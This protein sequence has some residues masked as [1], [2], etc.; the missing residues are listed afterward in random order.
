M[1]GREE[2][3]R[4]VAMGIARVLDVLETLGQANTSTVILMGS[5]ARELTHDRSDIDILVIR[6]DEHDG[7]RRIALDRPGHIDLQQDTRTRFLKRLE[8]GDDYPAWALRFGVPVRD[9]GCWWDGQVRAEKSNPHWPDWRLK[10][11]QARRR[12]TMA[13]GLLDVGDMIAA[14]EEL[15][16][17]ASQVARAILLK[18]GEFPLS[19]MEL[20]SQLQ[21]R[22]PGL[23]DFLS[24][25]IAGGGL[26]LDP[27][28]L[29]HGEAL[30]KQEIDWL[31]GQWLVESGEWRVAG[32]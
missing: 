2:V 8:E 13:E 32:G 1:Y 10:I 20:P 12:L 25:L 17:A 23:A 7:D 9:P 19:R 18:H 6:P 21:N 26:G 5:C 27:D 4:K 31:R 15:M 29:R 14:S 24:R 28:A 3:S 30:L 22:S 16:F 11:G